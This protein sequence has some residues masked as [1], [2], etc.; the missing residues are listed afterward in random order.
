[1]PLKD[2][3]FKPVINMPHLKRLGTLTRIT[4]TLVSRRTVDP[5]ASAKIEETGRKL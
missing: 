5:H 2:R 3:D 4:G 1:M